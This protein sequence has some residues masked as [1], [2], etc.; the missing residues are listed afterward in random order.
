MKPLPRK[1]TG[2]SALF[3]LAAWLLLSDSALSALYWNAGVRARDISVCF[4]GNAVSTRVNRVREIGAHLEHF[5]Y[6]ANIR[7]ISVNTK[8]ALA[9]ELGPAGNVNNLACPPAATKNN[10][11]YFDGDIRVALVSTNVS[12]DPPG[13]IPGKGCAEDKVGSSFS[14]PPNKL[15]DNR[16]CQYNLKLGD[17]AD[18]SGKPW[19]NHTLHEFGHALG[20]AHEHQRKDATCYEPG[21]DARG[22]DQGYMTPYDLQSVMNYIFKDQNGQPIGKSTIDGSACSPIGNYDHTGLSDWD[23]LGLHILYPEDNRVAE[24]VGTS[25]VRTT[26]TLKLQSAW[27]ARGAKMDFVAKDFV[28][29]LSGT[30]VS[31]TPDLNRMLRSAG[32]YVLQFSYKDFLGRDYSYQGV[33]RVL[34]PHEYNRL[35]AAITATALGMR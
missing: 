26:D 20:L 25:V 30:A 7:F 35:M 18:A 4:A 34:S 3:L 22:I 1:I 8:Q 16:P 21:N 32:S 33:V 10:Q 2:F 11:D 29:K 31:T 28:W 27:K 15:E 9:Y 13:K 19:L 23:K 14:H 17:D 12:V 5:G 6:A 24:F